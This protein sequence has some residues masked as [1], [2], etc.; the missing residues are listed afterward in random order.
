MAYPVLL[1]VDVQ[2]ALTGAHPWREGPF[3]ETIQKLQKA[4]R[5]RGRE[6]VFVRHDDGPGPEGL[7]FGTPGWEIAEAVAPLPG[8]KIFDKRFNSAFL[9]T[10]LEPYLRERDADTIV[11]VGMQTEYCLDATVKSAF[12]RGFRV[13]VPAGG[14]T[15]FDHGAFTAAQLSELFVNQIWKGRFAEILPPEE[16][17]R[18][19]LT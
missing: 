15:T 13:V 16:I 6:V 19:L 11:L 1:V 3:V 18:E 10:G 5:S 9:N 8:E 17:E 4:F 7:A 2:K 14:V 12:E